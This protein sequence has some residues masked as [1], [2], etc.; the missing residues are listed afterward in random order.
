MRRLRGET[1]LDRVFWWDMLLL[2][3]TINL[4]F[5]AAAVAAY[6]HGVPVWLAAVV[7]F[8]PLPWNALLTTCVWRG[9]AVRPDPQRTMLR[10]AA[11]AWLF[12][13]T[14]V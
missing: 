10:L 4:A 7:F 13:V 5:G 14:L 3:T 6:L 2:G 8:A 1:P 11:L 12:F 9:A